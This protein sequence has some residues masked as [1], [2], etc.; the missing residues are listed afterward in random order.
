MQFI[1]MIVSAELCYVVC[2]IRKEGGR[3]EDSARSEIVHEKAY[4]DESRQ[5]TA[6][7]ASHSSLLLSAHSHY[8][9]M[10]CADGWL[11]RKER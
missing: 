10:L 1:N 11:L 3:R 7:P 6:V 8:D 5:L 9:T 2:I 4:L